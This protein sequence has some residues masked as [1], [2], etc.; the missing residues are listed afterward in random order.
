[1]SVADKHAPYT[2]RRLKERHNPWISP[3]IVKKMY[4]RDYLNKKAVL[5]ND[6][7][8]WNQYRETRNAVQHDIL[9]AKKSHYDIEIT[10][11]KMILKKCGRK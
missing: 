9:K 7:I 3:D 1:M 4:R 6:D 8:F 11:R 5:L 10:K 2:E